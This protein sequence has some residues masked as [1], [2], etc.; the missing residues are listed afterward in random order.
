MNSKTVTPTSNTEGSLA[1][2]STAYLAPI[3]YYSKL[4]T[5]PACIIEHFEHFT[6]QSYRSRCDIYSPNGLKTLSVPLVKREHRQAVKDLKISYDYDW[7]KLHWR[8]LESSYRRS[9][10]F[11]YFEDD[12]Q[13]YYHNKKYDYLIDLNDALQH[14]MLSLLKRKPTYSFSSEYHKSYADADDYRTIISPKESIETDT[15][16][17]IKPYNQVF[18][19]RHGF[20]PNLS[21]V[22]LLFNQGSRAM[23]QL[24]IES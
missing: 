19:T 23:E 4:V 24:V 6:K 22:D 5:Y 21:I 10:F 18:E 1:I 3:Q 13:P 17:I 11:E 15:K 20:I 8:T 12:L 2:L 7:Q 14:E 16:F 9:P